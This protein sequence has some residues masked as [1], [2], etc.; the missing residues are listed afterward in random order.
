MTTSLSLDRWKV[1][2]TR[3]MVGGS[4][5]RTAVGMLILVILNGPHESWSQLSCAPP[6][7]Y[8]LSGEPHTLPDPVRRG[9]DSSPVRKLF[10]PGRGFDVGWR[11]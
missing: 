11:V 5:S 10:H 1:E 8:I 6:D 2:C 9:W 3:L 4:F 7:R